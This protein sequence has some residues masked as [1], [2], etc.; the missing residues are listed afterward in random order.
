M[1]KDMGFCHSGE[2]YPTNT[3]CKNCFQKVVHKT[4]NATGELIGNKI[5][6]KIVKPKPVPD[7][8]L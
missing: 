1:S 8:Y 5:V 6:K 4:A 3:G 7:K 2:I